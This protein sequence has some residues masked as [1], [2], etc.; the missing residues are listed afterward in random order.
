VEVLDA[1]VLGM[2]DAREPRA[3]GDWVGG[4]VWRRGSRVGVVGWPA[5]ERQGGTSSG[6]QHQE[7]AAV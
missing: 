1:D 7:A 3:R 5:G 2:A 6:E 4:G